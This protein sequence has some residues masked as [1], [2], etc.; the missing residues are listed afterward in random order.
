MCAQPSAAGATLAF[1]P[2]NQP[3]GALIEVVIQV[4]ALFGVGWLLKDKFSRPENG[5]L[6]GSNLLIWDCNACWHMTAANAFSAVVFDV[7]FLGFGED[8]LSRG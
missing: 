6:F 3:D 5:L 4:T 7:F 8:L 1:L 2:N